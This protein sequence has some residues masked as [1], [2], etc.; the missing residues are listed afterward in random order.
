MSGVEWSGVEMRDEWSCASV[1]EVQEKMNERT[2][3]QE[4]MQHQC[5]YSLSRW[6]SCSFKSC[7]TV[8]LPHA[9]YH[10]LSLHCLDR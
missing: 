2:Q 10:N 1:T 5:T 9:I 8:E 3:V 6:R 4:R 7:L